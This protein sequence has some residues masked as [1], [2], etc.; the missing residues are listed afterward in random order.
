MDVGSPATLPLED[1]LSTSYMLLGF[2]QAAHSIEEML[3]HLYDF[4]WVVTGMLH[5]RI[6]SFPQFRM[7]AATFGALNMTFIA[8]LLGT[9]PFVQRREF[10]ALTLAGVAGTIEVLNGIGHLGG[11][12]YFRSYVPGAGT[13]PLLLIVGVLV[14]R[15]L[16]RMATNF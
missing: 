4:F 11:A 13:A 10:W 8:V 5:S 2:A 7:N 14:L 1:G 6:A 12:V 15:K 16:R 9:V 3:T